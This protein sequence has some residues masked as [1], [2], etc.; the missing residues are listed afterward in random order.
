MRERFRQQLADV[1]GVVQVRGQGL[2]VGIELAV[3]CV[4]LVKKALDKRLLI[5]VTSDKV[6]RLL[7]AFVMQRQEA[8]QVVNIT[9]QLIKE[10]LITSK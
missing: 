4:E 3:P 1:V 2:I 5:N 9:C 8:E 7:P 6:V 10:F